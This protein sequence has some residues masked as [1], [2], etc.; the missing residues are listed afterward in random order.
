MKKDPKPMHVVASERAEAKHLAETILKL[1][2][3]IPA[4]VIN[5][6]GIMAARRF[7]EQMA[8]ARTVASA[9]TLNLA[10]LRAAMSEVNF[11]YRPQEQ[12]K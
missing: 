2:E 1:T 10:K 6:P 9:S 7:K 3:R 12:P 5:A 4:H 11:Y 8:K